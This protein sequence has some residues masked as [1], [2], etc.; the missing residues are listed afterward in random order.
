MF[1]SPAK[2][3]ELIEMLFVVCKLERQKVEASRTRYRALGPELILVYRLS[4]H[5]W[6]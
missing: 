1:T 4:A 5:R 2:T 6:L 3:A